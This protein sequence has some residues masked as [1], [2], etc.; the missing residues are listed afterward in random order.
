MLRLLAAI[1]A[2][3]GCTLTQAANADGADVP[4]RFENWPVVFYGPDAPVVP[5]GYS[6]TMSQSCS[7]HGYCRSALAWEL[8]SLRCNRTVQIITVPSESGG[9]REI[10]VRRC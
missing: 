9:M 6:L 4:Y 1:L 10:S 7:P 2:V 5:Y 8:P 3:L